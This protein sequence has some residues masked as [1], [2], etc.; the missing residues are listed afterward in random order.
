MLRCF[1][2]MGSPREQ[3]LQVLREVIGPLI[4]ADDGVI[5][6]VHADA[7][8]VALHLGG[9]YSGCPGNNLARRRII[10]PVIFSVV[11]GAQITITTGP[12]VPKGAELLAPGPA[13]PS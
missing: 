6:L 4:W 1:G 5:Y 9:R 10:E 12:L 3:V 2:T 7:D 8:S 11:P 13:D